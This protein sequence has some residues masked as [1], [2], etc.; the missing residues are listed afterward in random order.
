MNDGNSKGNYRKPVTFYK[1]ERFV[2]STF[3]AV[4]AQRGYSESEAMAIFQDWLDKRQISHVGPIGIETKP[5]IY[6]KN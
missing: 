6:E 1:G 4:A 5:A 3:L 2:F